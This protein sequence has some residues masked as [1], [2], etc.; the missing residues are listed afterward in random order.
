M[1]RLTLALGVGLLAG[2]A[3]APA[4]AAD[5]E[6]HAVS[7][8]E[9]YTRT[10]NVIHGGKAAVRVERPGKDVTLVLSAYHSV[11]W[12]VSVGPKSKLVEVI[13]CGSN[14]QAAAGVPDGVKVIE[15]F[16]GGRGGN[17][18]VQLNYQVES[19]RFRPGIRALHRLTGREVRSFQGAYRSEPD[20]PFVVD[21][22]Q[23]DPR[24]SSEYPEPAP[25]ANVP[26]VRFHAVRV[27]GGDRVQPPASYGQFTQAG[28]D[29]A[30]FVPLPGRVVRLAHDPAGNKH[31]GLTD[32]EIHEVDLR[33]RTSTKLDPGLNVPEVHWPGAIAFDGKRQRVLVVAQGYVYAYTP[34]TGAWA[35]LAEVPRGV[36]YAAIGYHAKADALYVLGAPRG[37][38]DGSPPTLYRLNDKGAVLKE[39]ELGAPMFPG[40][41]DRG[42]TGGHVQL[43]DA[44]DHLAVLVATGIGP[45]AGG[46]ADKESFLFLIDPK[47]DRVTLAWKE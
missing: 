5:G 43:A 8:Y 45:G 11:T 34:G 10:G 17:Q 6:V 37:G 7:V 41:I 20:R 23:D 42:P 46:R 27:V 30:T 19:A 18:P 16:R 39:T 25:A 1:A 2:L 38:D 31:Y 12:D 3:A 26:P 35:A 40:L 44:G 47:S 33:K 4:R 36:I 15:A 28:P 9:G 22:V 13:L 32:H 21:A 14:P 24:L 29:A